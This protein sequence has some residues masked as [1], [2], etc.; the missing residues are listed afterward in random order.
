I[1]IRLVRLQ[2]PVQLADQSPLGV[3]SLLSCKLAKLHSPLEIEPRVG[4]L[5]FV[6]RLDALDLAELGLVGAR[7]DLGQQI[8]DLNLLT[9]RE[10]DLLEET[11][12]PRPHSDSI[13]SF[14]GSNAVD[15]DWNVLS[16]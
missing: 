13:E 7:V 2:G 8:A 11:V 6:L 15:T 9:F 14:Y 1:D 3:H 16:D 12:D 10:F 5:R 4:Q